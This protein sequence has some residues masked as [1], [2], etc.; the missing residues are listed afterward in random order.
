MRLQYS[1]L[2][3]STRLI[4]LCGALDVQGVGDIEVDFVRLCAGELACVLV[5]LSRV[6]FISSIGIPPLINSAK[7]LA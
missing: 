2:N 4:Q 7:S 3:S 6:N 5:D 1:D